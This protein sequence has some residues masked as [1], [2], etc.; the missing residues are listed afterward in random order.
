MV[1]GINHPDA[2]LITAVIVPFGLLGIS[3]SFIL[4]ACS[5]LP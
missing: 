1:K 4:C 2:D 3:A 5:G